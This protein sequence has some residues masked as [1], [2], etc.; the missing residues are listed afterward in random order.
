[1]EIIVFIVGLVFSLLGGF[2]VW[3]GYRFR[4]TARE[5]AGRVVGY[6]VRQSKSRNSASQETYAPVVEYQYGGKTRQF[7]G[8]L[9]S[10]LISYQIGDRVPVLVAAQDA[11]DARLKASGMPVAGGIFFTI[12]VATMIFFFYIFQVSRFSLATAAFVIVVLLVQAGMA[13]RKHNIRSIDDVKSFIAGLKSL[14]SAYLQSNVQN[15]RTVITDPAQL[16]RYRAKNRMPVWVAAIFLVAGL[17]L[18]A[19]GVILALK[20]QAFLDTAVAAD[21]TIVDFVRRTSTSD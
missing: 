20:R 13:L 1:M 15:Q 6:E 2:L 16:V 5:A 14:K 10:S 11:D 17:G 4:K 18:C 21:G 9:A 19:G 8:R 3:D 12:G 7:T